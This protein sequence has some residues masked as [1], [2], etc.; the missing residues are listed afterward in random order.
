MLPASFTVKGASEQMLQT[1]AMIAP[2]SGLIM[3]HPGTAE[4]FMMLAV[5][6]AFVMDNIDTLSSV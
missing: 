3:S 5:S 6:I 2:F 1:R 4:L